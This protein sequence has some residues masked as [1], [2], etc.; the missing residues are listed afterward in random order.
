MIGEY[1]NKELDTAY[2]DYH[3]SMKRMIDEEVEKIRARYRWGG[4]EKNANTKT[5][6]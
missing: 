5:K 1:S 6:K 4:E 2:F 3:E